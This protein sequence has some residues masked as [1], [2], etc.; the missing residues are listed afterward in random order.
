MNKKVK[1]TC[2]LAIPIKN[3]KMNL[4]IK[5]N[6]LNI[7]VYFLPNTGMYMY[8]MQKTLLFL[9]LKK[10]GNREHSKFTEIHKYDG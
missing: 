2:N 5:M 9:N 4:F 7:L 6:T 3:V 10:L 1:I 8:S